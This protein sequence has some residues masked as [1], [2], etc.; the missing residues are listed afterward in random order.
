M[1]V[2]L[3]LTLIYIGALSQKNMCVFVW[4]EYWTAIIFLHNINQLV[5]VIE[6][7]NVFSEI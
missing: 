2:L 1:H 5:F 6:T 4:F 3:A 7:L